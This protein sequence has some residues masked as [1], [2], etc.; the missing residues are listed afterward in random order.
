MSL[1]NSK[2]I[3][4]FGGTGFVGSS[5]VRLLA[6]KG[7]QI[8]IATRE[9]FRENVIEI[10]STV[11][12]PGQ[13]KIEKINI[14][15]LEQIK[16]FI[17]GSDICLNLIGILYEKGNAK[18]KKLHFDFVKNLI[19]AIKEESSIDHFIHFSSLGVKENTESQ[20]LESKFQAEEQIKK[21]LK[22]FTIIKPS[23]V[24]GGVTDFTNM[25]AKLI[26]LFPIIPLAG[27]TV[28]FAP[29]YVGDIALGVE[30]IINQEIKNET[31]EFVGNEIF[32][33]QEILRIISN[34]IRV[35]NLIIPIPNWV[36]RI[37]GTILGLAPKP[38]LTLDQIKTLEA[39][40]NIATMK[41]KTLKDLG[42]DP[43]GLRKIIP[44]YLWRFRKEGQF[45]K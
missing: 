23:L 19:F 30:K 32:T 44:N 21:D 28:K 36:G 20:Y 39:G 2:K 3:C 26:K 8:K 45:A 27:S 17:R 13:I 40:D 34:E 18:F 35:K 10:K 24:F 12:D 11:S 15:S 14:N 9:P 25:F 33:L 7:H 1:V 5:I 29:V 43:Q 37:Q 22:N 16:S 6:K 42:I 31:I 41:N 38:M 4:L